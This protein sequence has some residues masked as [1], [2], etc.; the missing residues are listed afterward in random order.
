[1]IL[2]EIYG[3]M[4]RNSLPMNVKQE[5]RET[6]RLRYADGLGAGVSRVKTH[7]TRKYGKQT[8]MSGKLMTDTIDKIRRGK[9]LRTS[10]N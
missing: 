2:L 4:L 7:F 6:Q 9:K 8:K 10:K 3:M 1:L 5:S